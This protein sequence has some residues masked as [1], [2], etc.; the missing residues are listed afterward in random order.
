MLRGRFFVGVFGEVTELPEACFDS[1]TRTPSMPARLRLLYPIVLR[2]PGSSR[3]LAAG[4]PL[5]LW[6]YGTQR[7]SDRGLAWRTPSLRPARSALPPRREEPAT[8]VPESAAGRLP[9]FHNRN[10]SGGASVPLG[11]ARPRRRRNDS[12]PRRGN[13]QQASPSPSSQTPRALAS[14]PPLRNPWLHAAPVQGGALAWSFE[15]HFP[16]TAATSPWSWRESR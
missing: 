13:N 9:W 4:E 6:N 16:R 3:L 11:W 10:A 2:P 1:I 14:Q 7:A 5:Q 8:P 12:S 15:V